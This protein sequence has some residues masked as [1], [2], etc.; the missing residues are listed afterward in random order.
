MPNKPLENAETELKQ[1]KTKI[2]HSEKDLKEKSQQLLS[3]R[4]EAVAAENE[5]HTRSK[6]VESVQKALE[7]LPYEDGKMEALQKD[8]ASE[9]EVVQKSKVKGVVAKLIK[10]KDSSTLTALEVA[11][12]GKM[13]NVLVDTENTGKQ[14]LQ[15]VKVPLDAYMMDFVFSEREDGGIFDNK[16]GMDYHIPVSGG[17]VQESPMHIVHIAVEMAPIAKMNSSAN[18][19]DRDEEDDDDGENKYYHRVFDY[20]FSDL[21]KVCVFLHLR[22]DLFIFYSSGWL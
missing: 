22:S 13:F 4:E 7:S 14:L 20:C 1:L 5:L 10:V 6:D 9:L 2:S 8:R 3:K 11:A 12:G 21:P 19:G 17:V 15:N 16:S 18:N